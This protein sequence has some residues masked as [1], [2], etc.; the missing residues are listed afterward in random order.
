MQWVH[1]ASAPAYTCKQGACIVCIIRGIKIKLIF[2]GW[3]NGRQILLSMLIVNENRDLILMNS[4]KFATFDK[5]N[6]LQ[7]TCYVVN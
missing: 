5:M 2:C 7:I 1:L 4:E 6:P 3:Q